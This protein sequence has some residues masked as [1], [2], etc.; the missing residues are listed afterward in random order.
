M[1]ARR[2]L[3]ARL[4]GTGQQAT[5]D[6]KVARQGLAEDAPQRQLVECIAIAPPGG[7]GDEGDRFVGLVPAQ[8]SVCPVRYK[9]QKR[10]LTPA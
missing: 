10:A 7:G 8:Q 4:S 3:V 9:G 5:G 2:R 1:A 6:R